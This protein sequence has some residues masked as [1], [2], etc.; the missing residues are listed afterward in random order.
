MGNE[1]S[2]PRTGVGPGRANALA[3]L[4]VAPLQRFAQHNSPLGRRL[5]AE[6]LVETNPFVREVLLLIRELAVE[7]AQE[8]G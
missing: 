8:I 4:L 3:E 1:L 2:P 6:E 5:G 7:H